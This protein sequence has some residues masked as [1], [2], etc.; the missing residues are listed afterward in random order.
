MDRATLLKVWLFRALLLAGCSGLEAPPPGHGE[1]T[2]IDGSAGFAAFTGVAGRSLGGRAGHASALGSAAGRPALGGGGRAGAAE[3]LAGAGEA[4]GS[5][6]AG[7]AAGALYG[8]AGRSGRAGGGAGQ[9]AGGAG[10]R[11]SGGTDEGAGASGAAG[12]AGGSS[13]AGG[14]EPEVP[15]PA[16]FGEYVE[17]T[18][19]IKALEV[20]AAAPRPLAA[21]T[22]RVH[23]NG[24]TAHNRSIP[25]S[26]SAS[27]AEPFVLCSQHVAEAGAPCDLVPTNFQFNGDDAV[28][29]VC[30]GA[31]MDAIGRVGEDPGAAWG[32]GENTTVNT[33][34]R[35]ECSV[36]EGDAVADDTFDPGASWAS[37]GVDV[38]ADLG[39]YCAVGT[40]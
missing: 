15:V 31:V 23:A 2:E 7:S 16:W 26:G 12:A 20:V 24:S 27:T 28:V 37:A 10:A 9:R 35:R 17:G 33:T 8:G 40:P 5:G 39:Q 32:V 18:G 19:D 4:G 36:T 3:P 25:L 30:E 22:V 38:L 14:T 6:A 29:L 21:C 13:G 11:A 1:P 34:L